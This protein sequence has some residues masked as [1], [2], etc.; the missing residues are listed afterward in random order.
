MGNLT[1]KS[2]DSGSVEGVSPRPRRCLDLPATLPHDPSAD[3]VHDCFEHNSTGGAAH[4]A[5]AFCLRKTV[6]DC[7]Q[8]KKITHPYARKGALHTFTSSRAAGA[9]HA[10]S[11]TLIAPNGAAAGRFLWDSCHCKYISLN[12]LPLCGV[13]GT[14]SGSLLSTMPVRR[15]NG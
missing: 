9:L 12:V 7:L 10:I 2:A 6:K 13:V 15:L 5:R 3:R 14:S 11:G 8:D 1:G 4:S